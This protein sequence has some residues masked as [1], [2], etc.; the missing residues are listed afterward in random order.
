MKPGF[1][2]FA[3][4]MALGLVTVW[5]VLERVPSRTALEDERPHPTSSE[6]LADLDASRVALMTSQ[7]RIIQLEQQNLDLAVK[8]QGLLAQVNR[9]LPVP[10]R[11]R[12]VV[13]SADTNGPAG[14]A[15]LA[16]MRAAVRE[17]LRL[18]IEQELE[19]RMVQIHQTM[20]LTPEQEEVVRANLLDAL[21]EEFGLDAEEEFPVVTPKTENDTP[22]EPVQP[23]SPLESDEAAEP[24]ELEDDD[25]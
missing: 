12:P 3:G 21:E 6:L 2:G 18:Q 22:I 15:A 14:D 1:I 20:R 25:F 8:V 19:R 7:S 11:P 16:A 10:E 4:G 17:S 9:Q 24:S 13:I 23:T 5:M